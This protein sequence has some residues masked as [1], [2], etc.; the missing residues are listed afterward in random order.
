MNC[1]A[2]H[3]WRITAGLLLFALSVP[4]FAAEDLGPETHFISNAPQLI[5]EGKHSGEG[6]FSPDG[7]QLIF[8]SERE[9]GNPFYQI[10][11][12]RF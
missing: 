7:K 6:C 4:A 5:L 9:A 2:R 12:A 11:H 10:L 1:L 3:A 8:Q